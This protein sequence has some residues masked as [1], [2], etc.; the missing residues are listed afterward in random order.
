M[1]PIPNRPSLETYRYR[2]DP[3]NVVVDVGG[4]W[5]SA[6][7]D[8]DAPGCLPDR[9]LGTPLRDC[10]ADSATWSLYDLMIDSVREKQRPVTI[11]IRCDSP[12]ERRFCD[13]SMAPAD[14]GHIDF[15]SRMLRREPR[16]PVKVLEA[17][18]PRDARHWLK[19]CSVCKHAEV[20]PG[21]WVELEEAERRLRLFARARLPRVTHGLCEGCYRKGIEA[22]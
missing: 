18:A 7:R 10:I 21:V 2:I 22:L 9:I 6:C 19:V 5:L 12:G 1:P 17:E 4:N 16:A 3:A 14:D 15:E 13:L 8:N 11:E 20:E